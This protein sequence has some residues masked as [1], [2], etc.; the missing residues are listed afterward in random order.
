MKL[1]KKIFAMV[2][3]FHRLRM[4]LNAIHQKMQMWKTDWLLG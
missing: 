3:Q 4:I 1:K 2:K